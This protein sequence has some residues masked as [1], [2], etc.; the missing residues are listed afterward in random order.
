[1]QTAVLEIDDFRFYSC[2]MNFLTGN[3][4]EWY[5]EYSLLKE[6]IVLP[7]RYGSK[8]SRWYDAH[9]VYNTY[10]NKF[11]IMKAKKSEKRKSNI[12]PVKKKAKK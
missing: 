12:V 5:R 9:T 11:E 1:M 6:G 2:H 8:Q 7:E 10:I 4:I 3:I